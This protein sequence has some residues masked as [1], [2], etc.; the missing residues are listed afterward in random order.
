MPSDHNLA[1]ILESEG[2]YALPAAFV[3]ARRSV[4]VLAQRYAI[5]RQPVLDSKRVAKIRNA[6]SAEL[7]DLARD[8][9]LPETF[10]EM[11]APVVEAQAEYDAAEMAAALLN[12]ARTTAEA[13]L[14]SIVVRMADEFVSDSLRPA[15]AETLAEARKLAPKLAG[16]AVAD[17]EAV[18]NAPAAIQAAYREAKALAARYGKLR[19]AR[20]ALARLAGSGISPFMETRQEHPRWPANPVARL[21]AIA[22]SGIAWMPTFAEERQAQREALNRSAAETK[23]MRSRGVPVE[24]MAV[25]G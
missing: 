19:D 16:V 11:V 8:G 2:A 25:I 13:R 24:T 3:A 6:R 17:L 4:D 5:A 20:Q 18:L 21:L 15:H 1:T 14:R 23:A 22:E 9:T 12:A 7:V 10:V